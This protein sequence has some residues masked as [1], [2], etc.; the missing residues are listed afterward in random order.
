MISKIINMNRIGSHCSS[1]ALRTLLNTYGYNC[2]EDMCLGLGA[3][4]GFCYKTYQNVDYCFITG[5]NENIEEIC[6]GV[7]GLYFNTGKIDDSE[8]AWQ[9]IQR[10]ID[11]N[12]PVII[13]LDMMFLPYLVKRL[14]LERS[15]HFGSHEAIIVGYDLCKNTVLL[16]DYLWDEIQEISMEDFMK[17][18]ESVLSPISPEHG[19]K[20]ILQGKNN[21]I[22]KYEIYDAIKINVHKMKEPY[23]PNMG[24]SG[25]KLF[26][27]DVLKWKRFLNNEYKYSFAYMAYILIEKIGTGGG[28]FRRM[29]SRF[30]KET[31]EMTGVQEFREVSSI[32]IS[33]FKDWRNL[34]NIFY[35][36]SRN[37]T[38]GIYNLNDNDLFIFH[39]I[40][41]KEAESIDKLDQITKKGFWN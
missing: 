19:Y 36:S 22:T 21:V 7:L 29:Y 33:L 39:Q 30:L 9:I 16:L 18:R 20:V 13:Q 11:E 8:A 28:N 27:N 12:I 4:L 1:T 40:Y 25:I 34:A 6:C 17:A 37:I 32:Y 5:R 31:A 23:G 10:Y 14:N 41:D 15:F 2:T 3:G 24:L 38:S 35:Q 26:R